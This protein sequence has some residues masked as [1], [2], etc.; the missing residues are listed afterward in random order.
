[1]L[2]FLAI[3]MLAGSDGPGGIYFDNPWIAQFLGVVA[4]IFILFAGGLDTNW[5]SIRPVLAKGL[6]L[7]TLG[8]L[9]TTVILAFFVWYIA[10]LTFKES[11]LLGAIVS[12]TDAAAVFAILRSRNVHLKPRIRALLEFESGSN[13]PMAVFLTIVLTAAVVSQQYSGISFVLMFIQQMSL[14]AVFG[15]LTGKLLI[16]A[17]KKAN[18][19]Y[20]GLYPVLTIAGITLTYAVTTYLGGSG[21]LAVYMAGSDFGQGRFYP[22]AGAAAFSRRHS[23]AYADSDVSDIRIARF[24]IAAKGRDRHR[25]S[26]IACSHRCCT[27]VKRIHI[28]HFQ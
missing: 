12:S 28:A 19:D 24:S 8:V 13:D 21:F 22:Q 11:L 26:D 25:P 15:Y 27:A 17:I 23:M 10:E 16:M 18:F 5:Q 2:I 7:A 1:M 14:G 3:G 4:L 20:E 6:I 9:L